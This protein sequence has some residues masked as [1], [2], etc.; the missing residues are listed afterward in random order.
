MPCAACKA[1]RRQV[2]GSIV[3]VATDGGVSR[4]AEARPGALAGITDLV[5][6]NVRRAD[7]APLATASLSRLTASLCA[8]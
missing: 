7:L 8:R 6:L 1:M 4:R 3:A 5:L 2:D